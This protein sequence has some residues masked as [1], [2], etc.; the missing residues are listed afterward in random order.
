MGL[1]RYINQQPVH[2]GAYPFGSGRALDRTRVTRGGSWSEFEG[3]S[4]GNGH[5]SNLFGRNSIRKHHF[6]LLIWPIFIDWFIPIPIRNHWSVPPNIDP[7]KKGGWKISFQL[8]QISALRWTHTDPLLGSK[9]D[10]LFR[11][12]GGNR[13]KPQEDQVLTLSILR[14][15]LK[16]LGPCSSLNRG[17]EI[18]TVDSL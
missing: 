4:T 9:E 2:W 13:G 3:N 16:I 15:S 11:G 10:A 18:F 5:K 6:L 8:E 14:Y 1:Y 17:I 7:V 12:L